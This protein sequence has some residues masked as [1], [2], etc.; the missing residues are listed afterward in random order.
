MTNDE[1]ESTLNRKE[2]D[3]LD[4]AAEEQ[5]ASEWKLSVHDTIMLHDCGWKP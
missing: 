3:F 2:P 1:F 4:K 5:R